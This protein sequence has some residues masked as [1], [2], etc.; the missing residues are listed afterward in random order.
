MVK[1]PVRVSRGFTDLPVYLGHLCTNAVV[2]L[3]DGRM[4][5]KKVVHHDPPTLKHKLA[6][7][8]TKSFCLS[9]TV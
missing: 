2:D 9:L 6:I 8:C 5:H 7:D 1:Y 4:V 3:S